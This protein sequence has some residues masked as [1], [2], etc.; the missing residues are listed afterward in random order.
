MDLGISG[1]TALVLGGSQG[2]GLA[3]AKAL[4][5][6]GVKVAVNGRDADKAQ[7]A[8]A[9]IGAGAIAVPGDVSDR[10]ARTAIV[11]GARQLGPITILVTNAGGPP[12]GPVESHDEEVWMRALSTN[13]LAAIEFA[14]LVLPDMR[15]AGY[16]RIL[17]VTSFTVRETLSEHGCGDWRARWPHG[18]MRSLSHEVAADGNHGQQ[19]AARPHGH[20]RAGRGSTTPRPR[21]GAFP[22]EE[23]KARHGHKCADAAAWG[24]GG[25]RAGLCVP[26]FDTCCVHHRA[27]PSG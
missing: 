18:A 6:A 13:M 4:A 3:C 14:R 23:A 25:F 11:E 15:Q 24:G 2:L 20:G 21:T 10:E 1:R 26:V 22:P 27:E 7:H 9:E 16:G 12:P 17:N 8:A 19:P 5:E